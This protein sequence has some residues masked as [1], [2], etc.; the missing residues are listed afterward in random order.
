MDRGGRPSV[1]LSGPIQGKSREGAT[2]W[3]DIAHHVLSMVGINVYSPLR[4]EEYAVDPTTEMPA[5]AEMYGNVAVTAKGIV[6]RDR[7][8]T[9][10]C[11]LMIVYL[12]EADQVSIGTM[13]EVGWADAYGTLIVTVIDEVADD[14]HNHP[15][16]L[17]LS[18][19]TVADIHSATRL[20]TAIL[21]P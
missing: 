11:D 17:E 14:I 10:H 8:D 15:M 3:R 20:A 13:I 2:G 12:L 9:K 7:F 19:Y 1:Y 18:D 21:L 4:K 5:M 16:L 6:A